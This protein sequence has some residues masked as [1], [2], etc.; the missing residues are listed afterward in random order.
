LPLMTK[1]RYNTGS[2]SRGSASTLCDLYE[3]SQTP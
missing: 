1:T 2:T 3:W